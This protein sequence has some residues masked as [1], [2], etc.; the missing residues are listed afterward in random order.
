[1]RGPSVWLVLLPLFM[2]VGC[3][4]AQAAGSHRV[5]LPSLGRDATVTPTPSPTPRPPALVGQV[6]SG[7]GTSHRS[8]RGVVTGHQQTDALAGSTETLRAHGVFLVVFMDVMNPGLRSDY[9]GDSYSSDLWVED[10]ARHR[11][12]LAPLPYQIAAREAHGRLGVNDPV[13][14]GFTVP[15]VFVFDV[16]PDSTDLRIGQWSTEPVPPPDTPLPTA[17]PTATATATRTS[18]PTVTP[19][20]TPT[21]PPTTP[22]A[23]QAGMAI[24]YRAGPG[25]DGGVPGTT[26]IPPLT[27]LW[28]VDLGG[29]VSYPLIA[30]GR[31]FATSPLGGGRQ[32]SR[33]HALDARTGQPVWGPIT[34][35]GT[36]YHAYAAY[37]A[38]RL[39]VV[40]HDGLVRAFRAEGGTALWSQ[41]LGFGW[42]GNP[43]IASDGVL[44]VN[45]RELVA[46]DQTT[47]RVIWRRGFS[48]SYPSLASPSLSPEGVAL[49]N[50][51]Q[52]ALVDRLTGQP[53]WTS[54]AGGCVEGTSGRAVAY[55]SNRFVRLEQGGGVFDARTGDRLHA[56]AAEQPPAV[57]DQAVFAVNG[58]TLTATALETGDLLWNHVAS[59]AL[60]AGPIV[61]GPWVYVATASGGLLA[62]EGT[63]G[64]VG[65]TGSVGRAVPAPTEFSQGETLLADMNAGEG[66]LVVPAGQTLTAYRGG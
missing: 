18:T 50:S 25:H 66:L 53:R 41:H 1:V 30:G 35:E 61:V 32:G 52:L 22:I 4:S 7:L 42:F 60:T 57:S 19:T 65:W 64:R 49:S 9:V 45:G 48:T 36:Y 63:S 27:R 21:L 11:F 47:G 10:A 58:R 46:L 59:E 54:P 33:L 5:F 24:A 40:N 34:V 37:D 55:R 15:M 62:I 17:T 56:V 6:L 12:D 39:F 28:S 38:G 16:L 31:V 13:Q 8:L 43:P 3:G 2:L 29:N 23:A 14:P 26:V 51:C 20:A 44:Y